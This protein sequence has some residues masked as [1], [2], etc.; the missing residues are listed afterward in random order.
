MRRP[1]RP[2]AALQLLSM[3][4]P[5]WSRGRPDALPWPEVKRARANG[6]LPAWTEPACSIGCRT[7]LPPWLSDLLDW[8]SYALCLR[9]G[10]AG[11]ELDLV[12]LDLERGHV[13]V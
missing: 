5:R 10:L 8:R 9:L 13:V 4:T 11:V 3:P 7:F 12:E 1:A 2:P 6:D